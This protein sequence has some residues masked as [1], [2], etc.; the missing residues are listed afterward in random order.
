MQLWNLELWP[1]FF[2]LFFLF[3]WLPGLWVYETRFAKS[4][5][6]C[7]NNTMSNG[8]VKKNL[9]SSW[10]KEI[11]KK[12]IYGGLLW[13]IWLSLIIN[14]LIFSEFWPCV[15]LQWNN[16]ISMQKKNLK[17]GNELG[18][19]CILWFD[20]GFEGTKRTKP[21]ALMDD[22]LIFV[23]IDDLLIPL[24]SSSLHFF[25]PCPAGIAA[26]GRQPLVG[27]CRSELRPGALQ[28]SLQAHILFLQILKWMLYV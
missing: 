20:W 2:L 26:G 18:F 17:R 16:L 1:L 4:E 10:L 9:L 6:I 23:N 13:G 7:R 5:I 12:R 28:M 19:E 22:L 15:L 27:E 14:H 21:K 11:K 25:L 24:M 8:P 3:F